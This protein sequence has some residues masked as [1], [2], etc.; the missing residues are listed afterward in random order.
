MVTWFT[1]RSVDGFLQ[2]LGITY[3]MV[4]ILTLFHMLS[5]SGMGVFPETDNAVAHQFWIASRLVISA[6]WITAFV[7][8][9]RPI[10][11][12]PVLVFCILI[13]ILIQFSIQIY[14]VFPVC[15]GKDTGLTLFKS[16]SEYIA[17]IAQG[18]SIYLLYKNRDRFSNSIFKQIAVSLA[19][20]ILVGVCFTQYKSYKGFF[21][22]A[23]HAFQLISFIFIA[24]AI[25][26]TA[27]K[28]PIDLLFRNLKKSES[29]YKK[30]CDELEI[31]VSERT[32]AFKQ[33]NK[34][35]EF[36]I[37]ICKKKEE[38][39]Q[40]SEEVLEKR[41][42]VLESIYSIA[43][44]SSESNNLVYNHIARNLLVLFNVS[45]VSIC[46]I[47]DYNVSVLTNNNSENLSLPLNTFE[48]C[49]SCPVL[50]QLNNASTVFGNLAELN[51]KCINKSNGMSGSCLAVPVINKYEQINGCICIIN[52]SEQ[53]FSEEQLQ[54]IKIFARY[55]ANE[56]EKEKMV[57]ELLQNRELAILGQLTSGVAHEVRNPLNAIWSLTEAMFQELKD[58]PEFLEMLIYKEHIQNQVERLTK[59][60]REL[61][62]FGKP[63]M[64]CNEEAFLIGALCNETVNTWNASLKHKNHEV[65]VTIEDS[66]TFIMGDSIKIGQVIINLLDNA[67]SHSPEGSKI[68]ILI[69]PAKNGF[70][71]IVVQD[72]GEGI[73]LELMHHI[74]EPFFTTRKKGT[75]LGLPIVKN[76]VE[77]HGGAIDICN[78][79]P[80]PGVSVTIRLPV[81]CVTE[82]K[83]NNLQLSH[84]EN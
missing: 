60:M 65:I 61:L 47:K 22:Y 70:V 23:G 21:C 15:F 24:R 38:K 1:R 72:N 37:A 11:L 13:T 79:S 46:K 14:K 66:D 33:L 82:N 58:K 44:A 48:N 40:A 56:I 50:L 71:N 53:S 76:I 74:Y 36:Q 73:P 27:L 5:M 31:R 54:F 43:S 67:S 55:I 17:C 39:L 20:S 2:I 18:F 29:D 63:Y 62:E 7:F 32:T 52:L 34:A 41:N 49:S 45:F 28:E 57:K 10:R 78:N 84:A 42:K 16:T 83:I 35:L 81:G 26:I 51:S 12:E 64:K 77:I 9:N 6:G 3:L 59:L 80:S 75:G 25:L 4:A 68:K 8:C 19:A 30:S 69:K